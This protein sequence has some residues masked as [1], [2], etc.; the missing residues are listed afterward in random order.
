MSP[1]KHKGIFSYSF[2]MIYNLVKNGPCAGTTSEHP[3]K[4]KRISPF[5]N[6]TGIPFLQERAQSFFRQT[7]IIKS[8]YNPFTKLSRHC[9]C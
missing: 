5:D 3:W 6:V 8:L 7:L 9:P 1:E 2:E 4:Y